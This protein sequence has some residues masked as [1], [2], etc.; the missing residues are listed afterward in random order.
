MQ[1][2][3]NGPFKGSQFYFIV[4]MYGLPQ[5]CEK[6]DLMNLKIMK[7]IRIIFQDCK[8]QLL[9]AHFSNIYVSCL[10]A[11]LRKR[12]LEH[13]QKTNTYILSLISSAK[14]NQIMKVATHW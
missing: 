9:K 5:I 6:K 4:Y 12:T 14:L 1:K 13:K 10:S 2:P 11:L 7:L 8:N 3:C